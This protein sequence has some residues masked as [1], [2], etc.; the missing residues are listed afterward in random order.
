MQS[1]TTVAYSRGIR[2][3]APPTRF[4]DYVGPPPKRKSP[5]TWEQIQ[6]DLNRH[7]AETERARKEAQRNGTYETMAQVVERKEEEKAKRAEAKRIRDILRKRESRARERAARETAAAAA[8]KKA[9]GRKAEAKKKAA[10]KA[11]SKKATSQAEDTFF[12]SEIGVP[13]RD[14][15]PSLLTHSLSL[16]ELAEY[17]RSGC[18]LLANPRQGARGVT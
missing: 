3:K 11:K 5:R 1:R 9:E 14:G 12:V 16:S 4:G 15:T 6:A 13:A 18:L 7:I 2:R 10:A 17:A 8:A